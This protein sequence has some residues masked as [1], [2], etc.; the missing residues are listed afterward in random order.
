MDAL[1]STVFS[2]LDIFLYIFIY[3]SIY[4]K[5]FIYIYFSG[6][7]NSDFVSKLLI[8][9]IRLMGKTEISLLN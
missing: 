6:Y 3:L 9:L 8:R 1:K 2:L 7:G 4:L 5:L